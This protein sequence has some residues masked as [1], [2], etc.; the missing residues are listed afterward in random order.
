MA[1]KATIIGSKDGKLQSIAV[2]NA[3]EMREK[4]KKESFDGFGQVIYLDT[5]GG[6]RG[7]RGAKK[8]K[9][10]PKAKAK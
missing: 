9:A 1:R 5:S 6:T 8:P 7:K 2:G 4:F 3:A 10:K